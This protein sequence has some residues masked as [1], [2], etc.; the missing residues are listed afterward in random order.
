MAGDSKLRLV[1]EYLQREL[2]DYTISE[3]C[4]SDPQTLVFEIS[5]PSHSTLLKIRKCCVNQK[6][7]R[8]L[9]D[10]LNKIDIAY[11][12]KL[13]PDTDAFVISCAPDRM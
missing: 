9:V 12:I 10:M 5:T 6:S 3:K 4:V 7:T 1:R 2:S 11:Q 13:H 8:H